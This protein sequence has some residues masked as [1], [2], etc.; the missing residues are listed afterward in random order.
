MFLVVALVASGSLVVVG[1]ATSSYL[2]SPP[3]SMCPGANV[4]VLGPNVCVFN[5]T[6]SQTAIETDLNSISTQ[7]VPITSQFDSDRYAILFDPGTYGSAT[8]PLVFQVGYYTEVAGLGYM[9]QDTVINGAI[10][11]F[12]NSC[13]AR[14]S[15]CSSVD[16]FWR[17]MSNLT[18]NVDLPGSHP[19][20]APPVV[21]AHGP[22]C[23]NTEESWSASQADPI[24]RVIVNGSL[25]FQDYCASDDY[26]SGGFIAD[27]EVSRDLD[28]YGNQQYMVRNSDI[29]GAA[30]CPQGL[31]NMVYSGVEGAPSPVL[32]GQCEQNTVL[33]TSPVTEEEPFLY[34]DGDDRYS[35]FVPAVQHDSTGPS[36]ASGEEAGTSIPIST[37]FVANPS[38]PTPTINAALALGRNLILTPGIYKLDQPIVVNRHN[39]V[40]LGQGFATLVPQHGNAAMVIA[41]NNGVKLSGLIID[42]GPVNS[43]VLLSVG[44]STRSFRTASDPDLVQDVFFRIGG[45]ETTPV[46]AT[47]SLLDN[48][49]NSIIDDV[50][51]WRADHGNLVGWTENTASTGVAVT[52]DDV[53][54][55]GLA[56]EH[57]QKYEVIW[58]GQGGT[59][60][61]FQNELPYDPPSQSAWMAGP[62]QDGYPAF[63]VASKVKIFQGYGMGSYVVF[64][65]TSATLYDTQAFEVP[66][67]PDVQFHDVIAVWI[68]GSG[69]DDSI[70]NG[71]GGP[72]T[73][74]TPGTST[75]VDVASY[76]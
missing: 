32:S 25:V 4:A 22:G 16:N 50:W 46:G 51:A 53:T 26:A 44:T 39:T 1:L 54:A 67:T 69:G 52:G 33:S 12:N 55:Y 47:V 62:N 8:D 31:W 19:A 42:A 37:F 11:V 65:N 64:I 63:L 71:V 17:S 7:Q 13:T 45:A 40:V 34:S 38:T 72:V 41:S 35:V 76:P 29:G 56:V 43:P 6:M 10:D 30:G 59:D 74:T 18:L 15:N 73:S 57:Y 60:V 23:A 14:T 24:R 21:D 5:D 58:S 27:S 75:P 28:F 70:I 2:A 3:A 20:Y 9:P 61:F 36:W 68:G 48:A 49:D 66:D